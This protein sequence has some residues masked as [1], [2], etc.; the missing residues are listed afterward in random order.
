MLDTYLQAVTK[1]T[2]STISGS[3]LVIKGVADN[4]PIPASETLQPE[5]HT[6]A[7]NNTC[8]LN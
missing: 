8:I 1:T 5:Q 2:V 4:R 6:S 7:R 3:A